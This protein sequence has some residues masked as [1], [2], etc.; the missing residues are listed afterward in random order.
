MA[1]ITSH[2]V[3]INGI[4]VIGD[5]TKPP[6]SWLISKHQ[7]CVIESFHQASVQLPQ[8]LRTQTLMIDDD[9][10]PHNQGMII[11]CLT[12]MTKGVYSSALKYIPFPTLVLSSS[13]S[14]QQLY[15]FST[16]W[17]HMLG[18]YILTQTNHHGKGY[19]GLGMREF[20]PHPS[21]MEIQHY[22]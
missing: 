21:T 9:Q 19:N 7:V 4:H 18:I 20:G 2:L 14:S 11:I 5:Q 6:I 8:G 17:Y 1:T 15:Q 22:T 12:S 16:N 13:S 10:V 3:F